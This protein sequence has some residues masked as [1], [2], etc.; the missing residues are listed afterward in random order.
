[1]KV[2]FD[3]ICLA[4]GP[5]TGVA[6][7]FL[8]AIAA[9]AARWPGDVLVLL[10]EGTSAFDLPGARFLTA[11][12]G[13]IARQ[14]ALPALVGEHGCTLLHSPVA[15]VPLRCRVPVVNT[16]HDLPWR[17]TPAVERV[18]LRARL[19]TRLALRRANRVI[20][21]TQWTARQVAEELPAAA[22]RTR[23]VPHGVVHPAAPAPPD[24][25]RGPFLV[26]GDDR[27]RK[28]HARIRAAHALARARCSDLPDV[29][30]L[31]PPRGWVAEDVKYERIRRT[32]ALL[33]LSLVEGFG[34]PAIEAMAHG[35]PVLAADAAALPEVCGGAALLADPLDVEAMAQAMVRI[36]RDEA[37]RAQLQA[38]G[39]RRAAGF[40]PVAAAA[41]WRAVHEELAR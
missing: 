23:I 38:A 32:R 39:L 18:H 20:A 16:V 9:Y 1:M 31:G 15:A 33:Q 28:N 5:P 36:H 30:F 25:Q 19:A 7:A 27:P 3:A 35:V 41:A 40:T 17:C 26:L 21:P 11:P 29:E 6:R 14:F 2:A 37:L 13:T 10:P 22:A 8:N 12:R 34:M 24:L 4:V